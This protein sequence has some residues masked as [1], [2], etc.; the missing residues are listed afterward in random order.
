VFVTQP[1]YHR[2]YARSST[3]IYTANYC[4]FS[5]RLRRV[6]IFFFILDDRFTSACF[7]LGARIRAPE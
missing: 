4:P 5:R 2:F 6:Y 3:S 1:T 7:L